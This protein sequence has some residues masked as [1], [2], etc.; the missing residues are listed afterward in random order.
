LPGF[1]TLNLCRNWQNALQ[2]KRMYNLNKSDL[3]NGQMRGDANVTMI[4]LVV[5]VAMC[6]GYGCRRHAQHRGDRQ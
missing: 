2:L 5:E 6:G 3:L 4:G 1:E